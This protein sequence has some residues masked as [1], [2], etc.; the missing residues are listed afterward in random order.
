MYLHVEYTAGSDIMLY[1]KWGRK[2]ELKIQLFDPRGT[3]MW[4]RN[5]L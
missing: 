3:S 4:R 2:E 1:S 5:I